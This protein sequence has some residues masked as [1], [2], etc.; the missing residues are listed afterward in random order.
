VVGL[1]TAAIVSSSISVA[2]AGDSS[3]PVT[4]SAAGNA[5]RVWKDSKDAPAADTG[6][7]E[8]T[9]GDRRSGQVVIEL[10][11]DS[12][13]VEGSKVPIVPEGKFTGRGKPLLKTALTQST[14]TSYATDTGTQSL[15]T[16]AGVSAPHEYRFPLT[17]SAGTTASLISDG[18]VAFMDKE[19]VFRGEVNSPWAYDAKGQ[20]IP[21]SFRLEGSTLVQTLTHGPGTAYPVTA[22]PSIQWVPMPVLAVSGIEIRMFA[23]IAAALAAGGAWAGCT[24]SKLTGTAAKIVN[25]I[26]TVV[27]VAGVAG[28]VN[29]VA[30]TY[31]N[32]GVQPLTCYGVYM[33][34]PGSGLRTMPG[35]DCG[36]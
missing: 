36:F 5:V 11:G 17:L 33:F 23:T 8:L 7:N 32:S 34:S 35:R 13:K 25:Q 24:F 31:A 27:G 16:V 22:D 9:S 14:V 29:Y 18:S 3:Y 2:H 6:K 26:C 1:S 19:G 10:P 20:K 12:V 21:T 30:G 4:E 28:V 15:I